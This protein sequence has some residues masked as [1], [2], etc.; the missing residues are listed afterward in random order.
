LNIAAMVLSNLKSGKEINYLFGVHSGVGWVASELFQ[1][2]LIL[3]KILRPDFSFK[4]YGLK[5]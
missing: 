1:M 2:V 5:G 3:L 4:S